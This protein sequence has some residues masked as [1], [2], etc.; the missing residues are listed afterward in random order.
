VREWADAF[1]RG[2][3]ERLW[4]FECESVE[5]GYR[6]NSARPMA[7]LGHD[8]YLGFYRGFFDT[9][10]TF[11]M[12]FESLETAVS[13]QLGMA[14]GWFIEDFQH[15]G[16]APERAR[17]RFS[18]TMRKDEDGWKILLFH[19]DIQ[20]FDEDGRYPRSLTATKE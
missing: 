6:S 19:R 3:F 15:K 9:F 2:D 7:E 10:E 1:T 4:Q 17:V 20:P 13:G 12:T 14:W 8:Q 16:V 11:R 18:Q 5:F